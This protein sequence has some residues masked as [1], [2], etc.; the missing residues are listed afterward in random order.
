MHQ[1]KLLVEL[2]IL[3]LLKNDGMKPQNPGQTWGAVPPT[4]YSDIPTRG[5][6]IS[7]LLWGGG[8]VCLV[9]LALP[10][11]QAHLFGA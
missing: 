9:R 1:I 3:L 2:V 5:E 8:C 6:G 7:P 11:S 10:S 4:S